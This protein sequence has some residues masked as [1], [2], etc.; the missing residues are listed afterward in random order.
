MLR[1][2]NKKRVAKA[3]DTERLFSKAIK[4]FGSDMDRLAGS[5][6]IASSYDQDYFIIDSTDAPSRWL[7]SACSRPRPHWQNAAIVKLI[8]SPLR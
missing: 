4:A 3:I 7:Q 5:T 8:L 6:R 1:S 2:R